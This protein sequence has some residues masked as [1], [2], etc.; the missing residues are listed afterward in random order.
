MHHNM[1]GDTQVGAA[2]MNHKEGLQ[3]YTYPTTKQV[4]EKQ[5][6]KPTK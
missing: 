1:T 6:E 4:L 5:R 3:T 2:S